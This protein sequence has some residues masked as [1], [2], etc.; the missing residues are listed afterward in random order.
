[1]E[2]SVFLAQVLGPAFIIAGLGT[3]LNL[4]H[5]LSAAKDFIKNPGLLLAGE[6]AELI[7][8]LLLVMSHN[9]WVADWPVIITILGWAM[10]IEAVVLLVISPDSLRKTAGRFMTPRAGIIKAV[11]SILLGA[12]LCVPAFI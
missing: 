8:G 1:M 7:A 9:V 5:T 10:V 4:K 3:L 2:N 12:Y 6:Y 11:L